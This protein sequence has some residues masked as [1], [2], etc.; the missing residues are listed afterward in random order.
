MDEVVEIINQSIDS[1]K[2]P[3]E[4]MILGG[5]NQHVEFKA[6]FMFSAREEGIENQKPKDRI[7]EVLKMSI[8]KEIA[9]FMNSN[10]GTILIGINDSHPHRP[11]GIV[12]EEIEYSGNEDRYRLNI[13]NY[14]RGKG[15]IPDEFSQN[16]EL[17]IIEYQGERIVRI[18]VFPSIEEVWIKEKGNTNG[19]GYIRSDTSTEPLSNESFVNHWKMKREKQKQ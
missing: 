16:Y 13:D 6:S 7:K 9:G 15:R 17:N 14:I 4:E 18:D 8:V 3:I 2:P 1:Y 10:R 11:T 5:E 12:S 19:V